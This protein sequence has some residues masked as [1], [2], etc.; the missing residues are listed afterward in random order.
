[1]DHAIFSLAQNAIL[2][3]PHS[4]IVFIHYMQNKPLPVTA[5]LRRAIEQLEGRSFA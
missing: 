1:M 2:A 3:E 4:A 5:E